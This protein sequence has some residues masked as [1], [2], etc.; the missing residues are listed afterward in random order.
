M[1]VRQHEVIRAAILLVCTA[2]LIGLPAASGAVATSADT[3]PVQKAPAVVPVYP[4]DF[5]EPLVPFEPAQPRPP[6]AAAEADAMAW[7]MT[8]QLRE[9]KNNKKGALAA[10]LKAVELDPKAARAY[11]ALVSV[12]LELNQT[13]DAIKYAF[14]AIELNPNN[15]QLLQLLGLRLAAQ[16]KLSEAIGLFNKA[17]QSETLDKTSVSFVLLQRHLAVVYWLDGQKEKSAAAYAAVFEALTQAGKYKLDDQTRQRLL[18]DRNTSFE[19]MGHVFLAAGRTELAVRAFE[20]A[21]GRPE[22]KRGH[23]SYNL[24][25]VYL[26]TGQ[27]AKAMEQLQVYLDA[28]LQSKEKAAY[29]LLAEILAK[30]GKTDELI[31]RLERL[32]ERDSKNSYLL[33]FLGEQYLTGNRLQDAESHYQRILAVS[34]SAEAY[35][36]LAQVHR[37]QN[38]AEPLLD[39]LP[40]ALAKAPDDARFM[41]ALDREIGE[42]AL[43]E[44]LVEALIAVG[45]QHLTATPPQLNFERAYILA[46]LAAAAGNTKAGIEF[47]RFALG[48]RKAWITGNRAVLE[49]Y[50]GSVSAFADQLLRE[51]EHAEAAEI[52]RAAADD[53]ILKPLRTQFLF[54]LS[55]AQSQKGDTAA[56]LAAIREARQ[57]R[58]HYLLHFQEARIHYRSKQWDQAIRL[59]QG[60]IAAFPD[61]KELVRRC[62]FSLSSIYVLQGELQKGEKVLE[63][64]YAAEP[65]HPTVNN[66]LGYLYADQGKNLQKAEKMIRKA[67][68]AEP[69]NPAFLDS[70]GWVLYKLGRYAEALPY[71]GKAAQLL[72]SDD[73]TILDHLGDCYH[74]LRR[75]DVALEAWQK[76]L[77][78]AK[79]DA[80]ADKELIERI[81]RKLKES[82]SNASSSSGPQQSTPPVKAPQ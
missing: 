40:R 18:A 42:I 80:Q 69:E 72:S 77:G 4:R 61:E 74:G 48:A 50:A 15:H 47:Y 20:Q 13:D 12:A 71:L 79:N 27:F 43:N 75:P 53:T 28:Q 23:Q 24:A 26:Q 55:E 31:P 21:A 35:L 5:D 59:F 70:M 29:R 10:Y 64:V 1:S 82:G 66:D 14:K 3:Q 19:Q 57:G 58:D 78:A 22:G 73:P 39:T 38:H 76:A 16:S 81:E 30:T 7:Y 56:A 17:L 54:Q 45:R 25:R 32:A 6:Q 44:K 62:Q 37:R 8:G 67:I 9:R 34:E 11:Q 60:F 49:R 46:R 36:G 65:D 2:H 68:L 63:E 51:G 33:L 41:G 52:A